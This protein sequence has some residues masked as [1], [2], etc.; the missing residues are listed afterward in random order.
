MCRVFGCVA[1][2]PV[3][4]RH[5]L[6]DAAN[7]LIRQSE[8]YHAAWQAKGAA[9]DRAFRRKMAVAAPILVAAAALAIYALV[10]R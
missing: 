3:S 4:I 8:E 5:E 10:G 2:E 7:P 9:H 1:S 6:L